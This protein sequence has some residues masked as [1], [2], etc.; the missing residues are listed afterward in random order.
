M[1]VE[2]KRKSGSPVDG[3]SV[4]ML[5]EWREEATKT[6]TVFYDCVLE[7]DGEVY[8]ANQKWGTTVME[9]RRVSELC[10]TCR[11][12]HGPDNDK[13]ITPV[14]QAMMLGYLRSKGHSE[15]RIPKLFTLASKRQAEYAKAWRTREKTRAEAAEC[16][17]LSDIGAK[18]KVTVQ[19]N[20]PTGQMH[21][22]YVTPVREAAEKKIKAKLK[23]YAAPLQEKCRVM[24]ILLGPYPESRSAVIRHQYY[25]A[26]Q[27][28]IRKACQDVAIALRE[29]VLTLGLTESIDGDVRETLK[30]DTQREAEA[31]ILRASRILL[32]GLK[33]FGARND[34]EV[35]E[36]DTEDWGVMHAH[37]QGVWDIGVKFDRSKKAKLGVLFERYRKE[38]AGEGD[39][40]TE[41]GPEAA[42]VDGDQEEDD[43]GAEA[44]AEVDGSEG[45]EE[46]GD[47]DDV[48]WSSS[49]S[50]SP[51]SSTIL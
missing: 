10:K 24:G 44:E 16:Q 22:K 31:T 6:M 4:A 34:Y 37:F 14:I 38:N 21:L 47:E 28:H 9:E 51:I 25:L 48:C 23:L 33:E 49:P 7:A 39:E 45:E 42:V 2:K 12:V 26:M 50:L 17:V 20:F 1:S 8:T 43:D 3:M 19:T 36:V 15:E 46:K 29:K 27:K 5:K 30:V 11:A 18:F 13:G 32:D 35:R 41:E 40:V